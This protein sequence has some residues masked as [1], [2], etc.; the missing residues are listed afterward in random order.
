MCFGDAIWSVERSGLDILRGADD[1]HWNVL[2]ILTKACL[3]V[4]I[5]R[6]VQ[7]QPLQYPTSR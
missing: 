2:S 4:V 1:M 3:V 5:Q 6:L 7:H